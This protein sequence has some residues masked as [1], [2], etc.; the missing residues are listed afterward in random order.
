MRLLNGVAH[1]QSGNITVQWNFKSM[2][3]LKVK[4]AFSRLFLR[5]FATEILQSAFNNLVRQVRRTLDRGRIGN[6]DTFLLWI[7]RFFLEFNRLSDF[8]LPLVT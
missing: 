5:Q 8:K 2:I 1:F 7:I 4:L 3:V 6:D